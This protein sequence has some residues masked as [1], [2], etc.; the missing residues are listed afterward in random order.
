LPGL[1]VVALLSGLVGV[2][3][4]DGWGCRGHVGGVEGRF[5]GNLIMGSPRADVGGFWSAEKAKLG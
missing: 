3:Y 1:D 4:G 5:G 2:V